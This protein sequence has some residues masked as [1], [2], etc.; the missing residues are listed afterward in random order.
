MRLKPVVATISLLVVL[1]LT[2]FSLGGCNFGGGDAPT[3]I[4]LM[5]KLPDYN[6]VKTE[7]VQGYLAG[8]AEGGALLAGNPELVAIIEVVDTVSL[9]YQQEEAINVQAYSHKEFPLSA[10]VVFIGD[11]NK[12]TDINTLLKCAPLTAASPQLQPCMHHYIYEIENN[13]YYMAYAGSTAEICR[14]FCDNLAGCEA[15]QS[16]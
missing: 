4:E 6:S 10:G 7:N 14:D 12:I 2:I 5:P 13:K 9:C 8:L 3:V 15:S 16:K 11:H 1:L